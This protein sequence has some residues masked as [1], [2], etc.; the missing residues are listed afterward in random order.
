MSSPALLGFDLKLDVPLRESNPG[1]CWF[2]PRPVAVPGA[3]RGGLPSVILTIQKELTADDFY[4]G[5]YFMRTDDLG[6]T[7]AGPTPI[8]SLDWRHDGD[9][10]VTVADVTPGWHAATTRVIAM[11]AQVRHNK[12]GVAL[13]DVH[14]A[15]STA[16]TVYDPAK[17][18]W[19][20]WR[21]LE[22]PADKAFDFSRN[23]CSQWLAEPDGSL[24]AAFY[25]GVSA[26]VPWGV[27]VFRCKFDGET[28]SC[29]ERG[30]TLELNTG[31]GFAEPSLAKF[32][33]RWFLT[34]RSDEHGYV[35]VSKDGLRYGPI[36]PWLFDDGAELGSYNTQQH[37]LSHSDGL[38]LC[39][40][41]RGANNDHII[42]NRAPL[43]IAQVDPDTLHVIRKTERVLMP[44]RGLMLGNFGAAAITRGESWV[45]DSEYLCHKVGIKPTPQGGDGS[46]FVARVRWAKPNRDVAW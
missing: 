15:H 41:R 23:A 24:L 29:G 8:A 44:E 26:A 30:N 16:Y 40:T 31:R 17:D 46:T 2:H 43:F 9:T 7:W 14:R 34:I 4:S 33:G 11:G 37:W 38:F 45:T 25:H 20:P 1:Y 22:M 39:Y 28:L 5:L 3:G 10:I 12:A 19:Q 6:K 35:S 21:V 27:T 42:R 32:A 18:A 36:K 13:E